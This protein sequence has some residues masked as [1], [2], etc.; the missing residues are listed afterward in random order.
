MSRRLSVRFFILSNEPNLE[1][2][3]L[4]S[5]DPAVSS[6]PEVLLLLLLI[7]GTDFVVLTLRGSISAFIFLFFPLSSHSFFAGSSAKTHNAHKPPC[8][9]PFFKKIFNS[10]LF[11]YHFLYTRHCKW[12]IH[13]LTSRNY[14]DYRVLILAVWG[15]YLYDAK[16]QNCWSLGTLG[17]KFSDRCL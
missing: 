12:R 11:W 3:S 10:E 17:W 2:S 13:E 6:Y 8:A 5:G 14:Y 15:L 1:S 9:L 4:G 16:L 7:S